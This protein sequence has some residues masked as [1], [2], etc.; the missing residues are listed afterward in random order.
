MISPMV[1]GE[2]TKVRRAPIMMEDYSQLGTGCTVLP[3]VTLHEGAVSGS[4]SLLLGDLSPWSVNFGIPC[5]YHSAR[6]K[7]IKLLGK[8]LL[9]KK[10]SVDE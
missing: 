5:R 9:M 2:L 4:C 3:G 6:K 7:N 10:E 8:N 1:P